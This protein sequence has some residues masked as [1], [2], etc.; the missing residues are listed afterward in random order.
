MQNTLKPSSVCYLYLCFYYSI[1]ICNG[2]QLH[3]NNVLL[4]C[5]IARSSSRLA[6]CS[7]SN[8][9]ACGNISLCHVSRLMEM[10]VVQLI[11][12]YSIHGYYCYYSIYWILSPLHCCGPF[13]MG[14]KNWTIR[15][16]LTR[17]VSARQDETFVWMRTYAWHKF[18]HNSTPIVGLNAW[19]SKY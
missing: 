13:G 15:K 7:I 17:A 4:L 6:Y 5:V 9:Y 10:M 19:C 14:F 8:A 18:D 2:L 16:A 3:A 11:T 12:T 1:S